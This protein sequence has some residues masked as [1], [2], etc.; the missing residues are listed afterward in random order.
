MN[1][2]QACVDQNLFG[3]WF[4]DLATWR[5]W[6]SFFAAAFALPMTPD[7]FAIFQRCTGRTAPPDTPISEGWLICGRR[8]GK[9]FIL[10]LVAVFLAAFKDYRPYLAPGE[11]ATVLVI[12]TDRRQARVILR[13][14]RGFLTMIP[15]L[16]AMVERET[17]EAFDLNNQ[18]TIEVGT[19][20]FRTVRGYTFAAVLADELAFWATDDAAEPDYEI[21]DAVRPGLATIPGAI[22]LCASSPYAKRGALHDAFR[23]HFGLDG[24]PILVWKAASRDMNPTLQQAVIDRAMERDPASAAAEWLAEFRN[25]IENFVAREAVEACIE[26]GMRERAPVP[27]RHYRAFCDPS[28]GSS[29]AMTLAISHADG[30]RAVIDAM[31]EVR[32][33]FSPEGVVDEFCSLLDRYGVGTVTGDRYAGEWPREQFRKRGITYEVSDLPKSDLYRE[34]LPALNSRTMVLLDSDRL[35]NQV[36]GLERRT[37]RSGRDSIDHAPGQHDDLAN[38]VAGAVWLVTR[39]EKSGWTVGPIPFLEAGPE[40]DHHH[41]DEWRRWHNKRGL[42]A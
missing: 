37:A 4:R 13:Y 32:P 40:S 35:L 10:A 7:Q 33:P 6:F 25:D 11:R 42:Q 23:R 16:K 28:G 31:R 5:A 21:L 17:A 18:V 36:A 19:A 26:R 12:A 9:S 1:I 24:D 29:D 30:E 38:A 20:S 39:A 34:M 27:G 8:A 41:Q 15:F 22:L 14:V 2:L 3:R